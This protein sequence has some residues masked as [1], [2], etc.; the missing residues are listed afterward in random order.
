ML[1]D[2][3]VLSFPIDRQNLYTA[4]EIVQLLPVFEVNNTYSRFI[5]ANKWVVKFLPNA[6]DRIK[7]HELRIKEG[8][9]KTLFIIHYSLFILEHLAKAL[10]LWSI[11]RHQTNETVSD[12]FLAFHPLDYKKKVLMKYKKH[13]KLYEV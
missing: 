12:S 11:K 2:E 6:L 9:T 4:H 10:Q 3:S 1:I 8:Q 5:N 7:N 13:L